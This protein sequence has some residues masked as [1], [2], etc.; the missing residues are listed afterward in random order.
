MIISQ[1]ESEFRALWKAL[2]KFMHNLV[3]SIPTIFYIFVR[4]VSL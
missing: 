4:G 3:L 1:I 2:A